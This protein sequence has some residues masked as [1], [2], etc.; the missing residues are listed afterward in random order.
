MLRGIKVAGFVEKVR[1][2]AGHH[3]AMGK[4]LGHPQLALVLFRQLHPHP[5]AKGG[6]RLAQIHRHIKNTAARHAHQLALG[7]LDLIVQ[8]TQ[9]TLARTRMVV[10]HKVHM[11]AHGLVKHL[12]VKALKEKA[13]R[14]SEHLGFKNEHVRNRGLNGLHGNPQNLNQ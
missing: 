5:P 11:A 8:A 4:A 12:L 7:L 9:H 14:I 1:A 10:L 13:A 6:R 2:L 3:K